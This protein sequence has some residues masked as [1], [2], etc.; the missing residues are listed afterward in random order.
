M[1]ALRA[2]WLMMRLS[3][4][5]STCGCGIL[6][7][8]IKRL[9]KKYIVAFWSGVIAV[10]VFV[11]F[12]GVL[13]GLLSFGVWPFETANYWIPVYLLLS[14]AG[15]CI[16]LLRRRYLFAGIGALCA[17]VYLILMALHWLPVLTRPV[18]EHKPNLRVLTANV[19]AHGNSPTPLLKLI[20]ETKPDIIVLQEVDEKWLDFL[21]P[22]EDV[23]EN[24]SFS[25]RYQGSGLDLAQFWNGKA[26]VQQEL[27]REGIPATLTK[28][29]VHSRQI[30]VMNVHTASPFSPQRA[31]NYQEQMRRL[32]EYIEDYEGILIVAGDFNSGLWSW[33]YKKLLKASGLRNVRDGFGILGTWPSFMGPLQIALDHILISPEIEVIRCWTVSGTGSDHSALIA[34]IYLE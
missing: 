11:P 28:V 18:S 25:P 16:S 17:F 12:I 3:S 23:Y 10:L 9:T 7:M 32:S 1:D 30:I 13:T 24:S 6:L 14:M 15:G 21:A 5:L 19:Y 29:T 22:L 27:C 8:A 34:D 31:R 26:D 33:H 4:L 2:S 20:Q